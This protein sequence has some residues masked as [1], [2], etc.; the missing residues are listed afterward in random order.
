MRVGFFVVVRKHVLNF[1]FRVSSRIFSFDQPCAVTVAAFG[2]F[3]AIG[4]SLSL[5]MSGM[6]TILSTL[7]QIFLAVLL[8]ACAVT[9]ISHIIYSCCRCQSTP[10]LSPGRYELILIVKA[11]AILTCL[12][13]P[14]YFAATLIRCIICPLFGGFEIYDS[15]YSWKS[16]PLVMCIAL[17]IVGL[18]WYGNLVTVVE[19]LLLVTAFLRLIESF[20]FYLR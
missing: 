9:V 8:A 7:L 1:I 2:S 14:F 19:S 12:G 13:L 3:V 16:K 11:I 15:F 6:M 10:S 17:V 5:S 18:L 20:F 4:A